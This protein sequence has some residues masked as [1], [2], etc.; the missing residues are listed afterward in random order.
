MKHVKNCS[1]L[2]NW[3]GGGESDI[4]ETFLR[5]RERKREIAK[6]VG[7]TL[8]LGQQDC[9]KKKRLETSK[10]SSKRVEEGESEYIREE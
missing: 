5:E 2:N 7:F 4:L 9:K 10:L 8:T 6:F 1:N 3:G